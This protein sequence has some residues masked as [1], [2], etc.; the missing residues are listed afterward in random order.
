MDKK[1]QYFIKKLKEEM[2][3]NQLKDT[4]KDLSVKELENMF[5]EY[6]CFLDF[7][8]IFSKIV[9]YQINGRRNK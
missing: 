9:D 8:I 5:P 4:K 6:I 2:I 3:F 7:K 1:E